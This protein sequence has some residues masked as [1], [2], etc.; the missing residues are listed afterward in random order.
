M[1]RLQPSTLHWPGELSAVLRQPDVLPR[2]REH[3]DT[4]RRY[5]PHQHSRL[6]LG[7]ELVAALRGRAQTFTKYAL[8]LPMVLP[9]V[10][11]VDIWAYMLTPTDGVVDTSLNALGIPSVKWLSNP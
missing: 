5:H 10:I 11:V 3:R 2:A 7:A 4:D 1:G 6:I 9:I 8:A